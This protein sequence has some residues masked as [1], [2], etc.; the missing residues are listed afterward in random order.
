M[1]EQIVYIKGV[2]RSASKLSTDPIKDTY[3]IFKNEQGQIKELFQ[4]ID[5]CLVIGTGAGK[6]I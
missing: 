5:P 3:G 6:I 4:I 1:G 2:L